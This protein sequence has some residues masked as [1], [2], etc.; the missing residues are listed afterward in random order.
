MNQ[1][2][3]ELTGKLNQS[4]NSIITMF[5]ENPDLRENMGDPKYTTEREAFSQ[6]MPELYKLMW[7][8]VMYA[9]LEAWYAAVVSITSGAIYDDQY[10]GTIF[11]MIERS[12]HQRKASFY[13]FIDKAGA[14]AITE[15]RPENP[16]RYEAAIARF[17]ITESDSMSHETRHKWFEWITDALK[18]SPGFP[19]DQTDNQFTKE[20][21]ALEPRRPPRKHTAINLKVI[22]AQLGAKAPIPAV[23]TDIF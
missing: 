22:D 15:H 13:A 10:W 9:Q 20:Y 4:L 3:L 12:L 21:L 1:R 8:S 19:S 2:K 14:R 11:P 17:R 7:Q 16:E 23:V 18:S 6:R 5:R